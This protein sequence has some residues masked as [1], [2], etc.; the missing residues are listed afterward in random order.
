M[1]KIMRVNEEAYL[2]LEELSQETGKSKQDLLSIALEKLSRE[3]FFRKVG[4]A[5]DRLKND[6][7]QW[8]DEIKERNEWEKIND[9]LDD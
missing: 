2:K 3:I 7:A 9:K 4:K 6:P 5:Y 8:N 1:S